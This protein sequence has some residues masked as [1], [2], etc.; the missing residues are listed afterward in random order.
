ML[1]VA[2][3]G[4]GGS[5]GMAAP[6]ILGT[7]SLQSG[8]GAQGKAGGVNAA[9]RALGIAVG[10]ITGTALYATN[11]TAP[12]AVAAVLLLLTVILSFCVNP[13]GRRAGSI[14]PAKA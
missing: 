6:A 7:I 14:T 2:M 13:V 10:P 11:H 9:A 8:R 3:S 12:F 5:M 4:L 1:L